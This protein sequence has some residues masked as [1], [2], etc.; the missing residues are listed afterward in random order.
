MADKERSKK[1]TENRQKKKGYKPYEDD[2]FG[3]K[4]SLL[5]Q[6]DDEID[7]PVKI[8]FVL[9]ENGTAADSKEDEEAKR[10]EEIAKSLNATIVNLDYEKMQE[11]KD[12]Y[13]QEELVSFAKPKKRKKKGKARTKDLDDEDMWPAS[14]ESSMDVDSNNDETGIKTTKTK[15]TAF[16][17]S[18]ATSNIDDVNFVDD[19][20]L[21]EALSRARKATLKKQLKNKPEDILQS[22]YNCAVCVKRN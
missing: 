5:G 14:V 4:K 15:M 10:R 6:Y 13:T 8:G 7:G 17:R 3:A 9:S 1:N 16:S 20:D 22:T 12:Y 2:G 19:D 18:N 11:V 21:Q